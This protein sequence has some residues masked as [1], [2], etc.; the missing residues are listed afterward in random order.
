[1]ALEDFNGREIWD[2]AWGEAESD[3]EEDD[4][5]DSELWGLTDK[6]GKAFP[7]LPEEEELR[8]REEVHPWPDLCC[9]GSGIHAIGC[10]FH[11]SSTP[12]VQFSMQ[13]VYQPVSQDGTS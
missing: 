7:E 9:H 2:A 6:R 13:R 11:R 1:M 3:G 5:E 4:D 10:N 8:E 12:G